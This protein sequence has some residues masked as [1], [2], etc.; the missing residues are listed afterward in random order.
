MKDHYG[1]AV[2]QLTKDPANDVM[3]AISPDGQWVAFASDRS[4][5]WDIYLI[6]QEWRAWM[7][8]VP[9][10]VDAAFLGFCRKWFERRGAPT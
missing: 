1:A 6:E 5:N 2:T 4:G 10:D 3:P 9:R 7:A 8:G